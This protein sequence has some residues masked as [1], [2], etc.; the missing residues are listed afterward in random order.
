MLKDLNSI[1]PSANVMATPMW[2][3]TM[4]VPPHAHIFLLHRGM[5]DTK[6]ISTSLLKPI[7]FDTRE[8]NSSA[9]ILYGKEEL[10]VEQ[11]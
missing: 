7:E 11:T 8:K 4:R 6:H 10:L 5:K 3:G 2:A 9:Y 1:T